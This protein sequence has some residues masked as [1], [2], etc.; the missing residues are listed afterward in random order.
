MHDLIIALQTGLDV[1]RRLLSLCTHLLFSL[2]LLIYYRQ[3]LLSPPCLCS[4][5]LLINIL[6]FSL[7]PF[8]PG[9]QI[10]RGGNTSLIDLSPQLKAASSKCKRLY[11][12]W[13]SWGR[14]HN[15]DHPAYKAAKKY[16]CSCLRLHRKNINDTFFASLDADFSDSQY[17]FRKTCKH[18]NPLSSESFTTRLSY[19]NHVYEGDELLVECRSCKRGES[20]NAAKGNSSS[21]LIALATIQRREPTY[22]SS[23]NWQI[24]IEV[25]TVQSVLHVG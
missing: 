11:R 9:L 15:V 25:T 22:Y 14:P 3:C 20:S 2:S 8:Y 5:P 4:P 12:R 18:T 13:V 1:L 10:C 16:F 7:P 21:D 19:Q 6:I 24:F 17:F 23:D